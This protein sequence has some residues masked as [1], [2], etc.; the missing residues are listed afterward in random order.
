MNSLLWYP[1]AETCMHPRSVLAALLTKHDDFEASLCSFLGTQTCVVWGSARAMMTL[2]LQV[3]KQA[4]TQNRD[5]VLIPAY[6]CYS[7]AASVARAG[8]KIIV[9]DLDPRTL[10]PDPD[11]LNRCAGS[12]TLAIVHQHL[13]G[14]PQPIEFV[15]NTSDRFGIPI[16][17]DAA[18]GLGGFLNGTPLGALGDYGVFSFGRGKPLAAGNGG[19]VTGERQAIN[20]LSKP[21]SSRCWIPLCMTMVVQVLSHP[22]LYG[23][24]ERLPLGLGK[25]VFNPGFSI[26]GMPLVMRRFAERSLANIGSCTDRRRNI[27]GVYKS[28]LKS[29]D[30]VSEPQGAVPAYPRFPFYAGPGEVSRQLFRLGVRRMY[31]RAVPD[32]PEIAQFLARSDH[33]VPGARQIAQNLVSLPTHS[34]ITPRLAREIS[35]LLVKGC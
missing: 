2:L 13:F 25:T 20:A 15:R 6:T 5:E 14:I 31:P 35:A 11:S 16:I 9:Y 30:M 4:D 28:C 1:P 29:S 7:V 12:A 17:E 22:L 34:R 23:L 24:V 18:Q 10:G 3:L 32:E 33:R 19:A 26:T 21:G 27:A 8:L